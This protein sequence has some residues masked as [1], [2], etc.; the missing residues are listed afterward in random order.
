MAERRYLTT[1]EV[2]QELRVSPDTVL[3]LIKRGELAALRISERIYRIPVPALARY[4]QG[5]VTRRPV[6]HRRVSDVADYG[7]GERTAE[8]TGRRAARA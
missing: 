8:V 4:L 2:A 5:P 3:R 6:V 7:I 1:G